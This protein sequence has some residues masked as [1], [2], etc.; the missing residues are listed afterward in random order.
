MFLRRWLWILPVA[1][2][3]ISFS[4]SARAQGMFYVEVKKE[5]TIYVFNQ[6]K[7]YKDFQENG[8]F[9][10]QIMHAGA[11]PNG[12]TLIFDSN[13]A[14]NLYNFKHDIPG[15]VI[16]PAVSGATTTTPETQEKLP[17]RFSGLMFGD[18][19][20]NTQRDDNIGSLPNVATGGAKDL[21]GFQ[22]RRVY[23]TF[24]DDLSK[25]FTTRFRLEADQ[26]AL[27]SNGKISVFVKDAYLQWKKAFAMSDLVF[28]MQPTPAFDVSEGAWGFRSLEKT[29]MDLRGIVPS[30]DLA[31]AVKGKLDEAGKYN[32]WV[33][34]GNGSGNSPE[35]D[36]FKRAYFHFRWIPTSRVQFTAYQ[37]I[38]A[39]PDI[40]NPNN[41]STLGNDSFTT[42]FFAAYSQKDKYSVGGETFF[43][44]AQNG[45]ATG[46]APNITFDSKK[47]LGISG[48]AWYQFTSRV[49][50]VGRYDHFDPNTNSAAKGDARELFI[51]ALFL[52]PYK[53]IYIMP[54]VE[55]ESYQKL[56]GGPSIKT[57]ITPRITWYWVFP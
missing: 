4:S 7:A 11:G 2:M 19:F 5:N 3:L 45:I 32:Y 54:N 17:Y 36:K 53:N 35:T 55:T 46:V 56:P 9:M 57:C 14:I 47:T 33:M 51:G 44:T 26:A 21:N 15:E 48:W 24:D 27:S 41:G 18:Y 30:R 16:E 50:L 8:Q 13:E 29:I 28:G 31:F 25:A 6:M 10:P 1:S 43:T 37:D 42:A 23:F 38:K 12:E 22:F 20:Y 39:A 34:V 49:G 52:K 40:T